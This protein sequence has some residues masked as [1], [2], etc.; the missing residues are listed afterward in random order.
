MEKANL[1]FRKGLKKE[2]LEIYTTLQSR[3]S[4]G[5]T[6]D[7]RAE[8]ENMRKLTLEELGQTEKQE[9]PEKEESKPKKKG[10]FR[11]KR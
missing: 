7:L 9:E 11:K 2:A 6:L 10:F 3:H 8:A 4:S 1:L 5:I